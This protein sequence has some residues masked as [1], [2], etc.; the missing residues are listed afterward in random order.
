MSRGYG[1]PRAWQRGV[2]GAR[3]VPADSLEARHVAEDEERRQAEMAPRFGWCGV[4]GD[5]V[6]EDKGVLHAAH[7]PVS[8]ERRRAS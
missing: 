1:R 7:C 6:D 4:C 5:V 3:P 8:A 2:I